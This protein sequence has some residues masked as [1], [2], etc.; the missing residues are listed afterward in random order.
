MKKMLLMVPLTSPG[1]RIFD[2]R[3]KHWIGLREFMYSLIFLQF[4]SP[5][6]VTSC[7]R[8]TSSSS[9][10]FWDLR[11]R[12]ASLLEISR[13]S[14]LMEILLSSYS[15]SGSLLLCCT[16]SSFSGESYFSYFFSWLFSFFLLGY[17][18]FLLFLFYFKS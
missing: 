12:R 14:L 9:V 3:C 2:Q 11:G 16:I 5:Y 18:R 17:L 8:R 4:F 6:C 15:S 7:F 10:H 13:L 1:L